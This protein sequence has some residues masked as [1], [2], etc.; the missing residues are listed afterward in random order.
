MLDA[1]LCFSALIVLCLVATAPGT[2]D[3]AV[4]W[5]MIVGTITIVSVVCTENLKPDYSGD[6][7]R[8]G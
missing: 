1:V 5:K 2:P 8:Q 7:V 4:I 3:R 6:E